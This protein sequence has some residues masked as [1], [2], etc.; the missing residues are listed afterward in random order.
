MQNITRLT[1]RHRVSIVPEVKYSFQN[2]KERSS[3]QHLCII[4]KKCSPASRNVGHRISLSI[5]PVP[6]RYASP[7][8]G[9]QH[10][11][12]SC[13]ERDASSA[14]LSLRS[15]AFSP[16]H[17]KVSLDA[18]NYLLQLLALCGTTAVSQATV[19]HSYR[20]KDR[21]LP[22]WTVTFIHEIIDYSGFQ[23]EWRSP[24]VKKFFHPRI[25]GS[26]GTR[27]GDTYQ[28]DFI[29]S[30]R[31]CCA[32]V[33]SKQFSQHHHSLGSVMYVMTL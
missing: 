23:K 16:S 15:S 26:G 6:T 7:V 31:N 2:V 13:I 27:V 17:L 5:S 14:G 30:G 4:A 33:V 9:T 21:L 11:A 20:T 18:F 32:S 10:V 8:Q 24:K 29:L 25:R 1:P 19:R 28:S 12:S 3:L 22:V